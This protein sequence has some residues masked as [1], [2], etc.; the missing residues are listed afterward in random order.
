[1]T[2]FPINQTV[3]AAGPVAVEIRNPAGQISVST[4]PG[5]TASKVQIAPAD[6]QN[7]SRHAAQNTTVTASPDGSSLSIEVPERFGRVGSVNLTVVVPDG[8]SVEAKTASAD[9]SIDGTLARV[10]AATASGDVW[11]GDV[12]DDATVRTASGDVTVRGVAG[13]TSVTTAS[14][15]ISLGAAAGHAGLSTA[16]GDIRAESVAAGMRARTASGDITVRSASGGR[17]EA[18]TVSGDVAIAVPRGIVA[19]LDLSALT[20]SVRSDLDDGATAPPAGGGL[21]LAARTV[22]GDIRISRAAATLGGAA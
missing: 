20:G 13:T 14:G 4:A 17:V 8:S 1:M 22:S 9:I 12:G 6:E 7:R 16:S 11:I 19:W 3:E 10:T 15:D 18:Q 21:E 2:D 5:I